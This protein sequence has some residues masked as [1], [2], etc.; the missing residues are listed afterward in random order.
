M[1]KIILLSLLLI[2]IGNAT[3]YKITHLKRGGSVNVRE[4]PAVRSR[5]VIG[6]IPAYATGI[7]I[8]QCRYNRQGQE[9]CYISYPKG[10]SH[11]E[12]WISRR[13]LTPMRGGSTSK[14]H[15][16]NFLQ[17]FY[18]AD[19]ENFLD[20]L[21]VFYRFPMQQYL[22]KKN[23]SFLQLR[24]QK[25]RFYKKWGKRDYRMTYLKI[26]KRRSNYIDVQ[27]TVRWK[28]SGHDKVSEGKDIQKLRLIP[29]GNTFKVLAMKNLSHYV[30]A[31]PKVVEEENLTLVNAE[32][33]LENEIITPSPSINSKLIAGYYIQVGSF[34]KEINPAYLSKISRF[35]YP[36]TIQK[37]VRPLK[38][39]TIRRVLIGPFN[40]SALAM[41]SLGEVRAKI[42]KNAYIQTLKL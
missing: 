15:I 4:V 28:M 41:D 3:T 39:I 14:Q 20:K 2:G 23:V 6:R 18:M 21:Q 10:G 26:L 17:N 8:R 7:K 40:S 32:V 11:L 12:G 30:K 42:N 37:V 24:S 33:V 25:V 34:F 19:E 22:W 27:A 31:K 35:G 5:T 9:W 36:Y 13:F 1:K 16:Q 29:K 38:D